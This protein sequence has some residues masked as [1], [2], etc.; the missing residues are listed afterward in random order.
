MDNHSKRPKTTEFLRHNRSMSIPSQLIS[1]GVVGH[2]CA[3]W[4]PVN[5]VSNIR[6]SHDNYSRNIPESNA[7]ALQR[8]KHDS[9]LVSARALLFE[10]VLQIL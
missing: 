5:L 3:C 8:A 9:T 10:Q 7:R 2:S 6:L 4:I 1:Y